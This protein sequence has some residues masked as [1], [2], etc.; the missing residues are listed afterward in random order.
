M[1]TEPLGFWSRSLADVPHPISQSFRGDGPQT[2]EQRRVTRRA[3]NLNTYIPH[4]SRPAP[5]HRGTLM[6][7]GVSRCCGGRRFKSIKL[8]CRV[9]F[10]ARS[11][12]AGRWEGV[13]PILLFPFSSLNLYS[14][15]RIS[16]PPRSKKPCP[17]LAGS[18]APPQVLMIESTVIGGIL[19]ETMAG[20]CGLYDARLRCHRY[21][22]R[23]LWTLGDGQSTAYGRIYS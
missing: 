15:S 11:N 8:P 19:Q 21:T 18:L 13:F 22:R 14:H 5:P 10:G 16:M 23:Q 12:G 1:R 9:G 6:G 20:S 7:R 17:S 2:H 3:S 4:K